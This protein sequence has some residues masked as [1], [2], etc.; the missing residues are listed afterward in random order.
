M[1]GRGRRARRG[2]RRGRSSPRAWTGWSWARRSSA[3]PTW[4]QA[5]SPRSD[6]S[7]W[8]PRWT[9]ATARPW[10][11]AGPRTRIG[12]PRRTCIARLRDAGVELFA[13][14]AIARDG[15][16]GGPGPRAARALGAGRGRPRPGHRLGRGLDARRRPDARGARLLRRDPGP[17]ALRGPA[18][19]RRGL[20]PLGALRPRRDLLGAGGR[21]VT[22]AGRSPVG[23]RDAGRGQR[24]NASRPGRPDRATWQRLR[25]SDPAAAQCPAAASSFLCASMTFWATCAGTSS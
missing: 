20:W 6:R 8:W 16:M 24:R 22:G 13:V 11:A 18:R 10:V 7:T 2:A 5:C 21:V 4:R 1:P 19:P 9:C 3:S 15:L 14:T 25:P 17:R 23:G 12:V